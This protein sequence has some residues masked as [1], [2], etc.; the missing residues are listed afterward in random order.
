MT[1]IEL[2]KPYS[3]KSDRRTVSLWELEVKTGLWLGN[4]STKRIPKAYADREVIE[5]NI[6]NSNSKRN[7]YPRMLVV[8]K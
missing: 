6:W 8:I 4:F 5:Y 2:M 3:N 1:L 7:F